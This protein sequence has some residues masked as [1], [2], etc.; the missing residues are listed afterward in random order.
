MLASLCGLHDF[1][2]FC[3]FSICMMNLGIY[4]FVLLY[5]L[6]RWVKAAFRSKKSVILQDFKCRF[7][8]SV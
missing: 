7:S 2:V 3:E 5:S 1:C 8:L 4:K 6:S